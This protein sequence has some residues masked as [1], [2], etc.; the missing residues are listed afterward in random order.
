VSEDVCTN[1]TGPVFAIEV[2]D[3][4][5]AGLDDGEEVFLGENLGIFGVAEGDPTGAVLRHLLHL[6]KAAL[7]ES[8]DVVGIEALKGGD[9][10]ID[11]VLDGARHREDLLL[12]D[13][14]NRSLVHLPLP[15]PHQISLQPIR[16]RLSSSLLPYP[17]TV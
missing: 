6:L 4:A 1:L 16:R 5:F 17:L 14:S 3:D 9:L 15:L 8:F 12:D 10:L 11:L 13:L 2:A 7:T